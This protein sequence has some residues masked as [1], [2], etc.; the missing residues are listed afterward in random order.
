MARH[1]WPAKVA[2][3]IPLVAWLADRFAAVARWRS[4]PLPVGLLLLLPVAVLIDVLDIFDETLPVVG[5]VGT[6]LLETA[7]VLGLTGRPTWALGLAGVDIIPGLDAF[8]PIATLT[9]LRELARAGWRDAPGG[10]VV[11]GVVVDR[12]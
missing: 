11:D 1:T 3:A 4:G 6:F 8:L 12:S 7:F 5:T 2:R 9:V 10:P